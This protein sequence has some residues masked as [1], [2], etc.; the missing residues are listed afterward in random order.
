L[1]HID[2]PAGE[3][4]FRL[5]KLKARVMDSAYLPRTLTAIDRSTLMT[6]ANMSIQ[7]PQ[8][9]S[10]NELYLRLQL[11]IRVVR[12]KGDVTPAGTADTSFV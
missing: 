3:C 10:D 11:A 12:P 1:D 7:F 5:Q 4:P 9:K 8:E 2:G 6:I